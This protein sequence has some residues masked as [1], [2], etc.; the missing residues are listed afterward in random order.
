[1]Y[2]DILWELAYLCDEQNWTDEKLMEV[3]GI[4]KWDTLQLFRD[5]VGCVKSIEQERFL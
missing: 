2:T 5:V 1:M 4:Y 3:C